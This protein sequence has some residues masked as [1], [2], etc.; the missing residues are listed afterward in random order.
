[1]Q[2]ATAKQG[3]SGA[4]RRKSLK[5][6]TTNVWESMGMDQYLSARAVSMRKATAKLMDS[7]EKDLLPY[8][9]STEFPAW[10]PEK[11]KPL[12]INGL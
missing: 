4:P 9:E 12:G 5:P 8:V 7:I 10:L 3:G 1:M 2:F 11:L 6:A